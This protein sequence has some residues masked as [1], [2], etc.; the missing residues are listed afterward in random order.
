MS[1]SCIF[2]EFVKIDE[3]TL[4]A[5]LSLASG[6]EFTIK[7]IMQCDELSA[8]LGHSVTLD[9]EQIVLHILQNDAPNINTS[10]MITLEQKLYQII[11]IF[12]SDGISELLLC[13]R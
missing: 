12:N 3:F 9:S 7:A 8:N 11:K 2:S 4:D 13:P 6:A 5:T 10:T 1:V